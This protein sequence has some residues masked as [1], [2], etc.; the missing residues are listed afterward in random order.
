MRIIDNIKNNHNQS[1][2]SILITADQMILAS[3]F[4]IEEFDEFV[5]DVAELG[6]KSIV[7]LTTL[8]DNSPDLFKKANS[9]YSFC[10]SCVQNSINFEVRVDN[11]LHGKIYIALKDT[12][13][14]KGIITSANFT[15]NGLKYS[16]EWGIEIDDKDLLQS[17]I[18]DLMKVSTDPLTNKEIELIVKAIDD[19]SKENPPIREPKPKLEITRYINDKMKVEI[20]K[21]ART[22]QIDLPDDTR[23]FLKPVGSSDYPFDETRKLSETIQE[24]HFSKRK[25]NAVRPGDILICYGVGTTKLLGYFRVLNEPFLLPDENTRWPWAVDSENLSPKYSLGWSSFNNTLSSAQSSYGYDKELTYVGG[26]SLG[27]LNF[28]ADKIRLNESFAQHLI[29]TIE[30]EVK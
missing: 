10:T 7:L 18:I 22:E 13:P 15:D 4:L 3:P 23:Y 26:R 21:V 5:H 17:L 28:G 16:H 24:M 27:A 25:P 2:Q 19:Y 29:N 30:Q 14:I 8:K 12:S 1:I 11:K 20:P 6:V 9:L